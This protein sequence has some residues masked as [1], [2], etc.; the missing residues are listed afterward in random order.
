[1]TFIPHID[2][3]NRWKNHFL[4]AAKK[5]TS[6]GIYVMENAQPEKAI[7]TGVSPMNAVVQRAE[8]TIKRHLE[9]AVY[10]P[11]KKSKSES[12]PSSP[13]KKK[14]RSYKTNHSNKTKK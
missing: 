13:K 11:E 4:Q 10:V 12:A 14:K 8:T 3:V 5:P 1:M 6:E 2:D 7:N 9:D